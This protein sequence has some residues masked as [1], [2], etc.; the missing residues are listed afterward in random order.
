MKVLVVNG[1]NLNLLGEREPDKY[2]TQTLEQ[3]NQ[4]LSEFAVQY[5]VEIDF[6]QSNIEGEIVEAIQKSRENYDGIILN[7][8]A[9][10]HTSVA[11]RDALLATK[12]PTV[13][14]HLSNVYSREDFRQTTYTTG[15]CIGQIAGFGGYGYKLALLALINSL[16]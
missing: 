9:Y 1:P 16:S 2:G 6:Y 11:I 14:V 13:E 8:A 15:V 4:E 7:P 5:N 12:M 10:T 3:I